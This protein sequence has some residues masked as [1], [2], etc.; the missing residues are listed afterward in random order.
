MLLKAPVT[1]FWK[2]LRYQKE[3]F[4]FQWK[5]ESSGPK[6][7]IYEALFL[8]EQRRKV[9]VILFEIGGLFIYTALSL[10]LS[11]AVAFRRSSK[12]LNY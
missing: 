3:E 1:R 2:S 10:R 6:K 9:C 7:K 8:S 12:F 11:L 4:M 5:C